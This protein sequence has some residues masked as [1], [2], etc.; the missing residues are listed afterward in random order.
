MDE[1]IHSIRMEVAFSIIVPVYNVAEYLSASIESV[2]TQTFSD[3]ECIFVD[4][5][6]TDG[7]GT[8]L[9]EYAV[10]DQR[11]RVIHQQNQGVS[12]ARNAAIDVAEGEYLLFLD[13]DDTLVPWALERLVQRI[14]ETNHPD[15]L[16]YQHQSV[17]SHDAA[18]PAKDVGE[19]LK[20]YNIS[21]EKDVRSAFSGFVGELLA[22]NGIFRRQ[23]IGPLRF[24][25]YPNGEDILFGAQAFYRSSSVVKSADVLYR[26]LSRDGSA[27]HSCTVRH[28]KSVMD[29]AILHVE[30]IREW[31]WYLVVKDLWQRK[32]RTYV[33]GGALT[34][35][36]N[37]AKCDKRD[38]WRIFFD[39]C[40]R[41][42]DSRAV[43]GW[44]L[45]A[46]RSVA[47]TRSRIICMLLMRLPWKIRA[48]AAKSNFLRKMRSRVTTFQTERRNVHA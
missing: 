23:M 32:L 44:E 25:P 42:V 3:W 10:K 38:A 2:V 19:V 34:V 6:S 26:Y 4:D 48:L 11:I 13:A 27:V 1:G 15:I 37:I 17:R 33:C 7:S 30:S 12:A 22:W 20:C 16:M 24:L 39:Y 46:W 9:D 47:V 5:G 8:I 28:L 21:D 14:T 18:Y 35:L 43:L 29:C 31:K 40:R 36:G 45:I 41:M